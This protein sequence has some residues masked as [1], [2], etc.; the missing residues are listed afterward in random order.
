MRPLTFNCIGHNLFGKCFLKR[1]IEGDT[2][3]RTS[4]VKTRK[5]KYAATVWI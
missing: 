4:D 2:L 3:G 1:V 5:K